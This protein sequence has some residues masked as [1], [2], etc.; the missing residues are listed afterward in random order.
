[1]AEH[2]NAKRMTI[3]GAILHWTQDNSFELVVRQNYGRPQGRETGIFPSQLEIGTKNGIVL[4]NLTSA[5]QFRLTSLFIA[6]TVY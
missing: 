5:A 2:V 3:M 4:E 1:V 6:M